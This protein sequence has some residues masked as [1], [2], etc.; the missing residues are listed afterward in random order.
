MTDR[1]ESY[2]RHIVAAARSVLDYT[3]GLS[4][5][6]FRQRRVIQDAVVRQLE[7]IGEAAKQVGQTTR[8]RFPTVPW[9][10]MAGMRDILIHHYFGVDLELV[11]ATRVESIPELVRAIEPALAGQRHSSRDAP[12]LRSPPSQRVQTDL[13]RTRIVVASQDLAECVRAYAKDFADHGEQRYIEHIDATPDELRAHVDSLI[14]A[15]SPDDHPPDHVP[16]TTFWLIDTQDRI[17]ASVRFR[18]YLTDALRGEGG[19]IGYDVAPSYRNQGVG[20][21]ALRKTLIRIAAESKILSV[22]VTC[23]ADN[24]PSRH[25]IRANEGIYVGSD[26][27]PRSGKDVLRFVIDLPE[28]AP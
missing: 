7:I 12:P 4:A 13:S 27:S 26:T 5:D 2:L 1:E 9:R 10:A 18:H 20:T 15:A 8:T 21:T 28:R 24:W 25:V 23:D 14:H 19:H 22:L 11:W 16:Q 3:V 17:L 6:M